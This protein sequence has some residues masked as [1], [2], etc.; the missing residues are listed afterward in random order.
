MSSDNGVR[1]SI[2]LG[3]YEFVLKNQPFH[4]A[5]TIEAMFLH[6]VVLHA[7]KPCH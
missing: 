1:T 4:I 3:E 2:L 6:T 5:E 7:G